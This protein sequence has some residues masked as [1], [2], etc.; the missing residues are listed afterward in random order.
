MPNLHDLK[1]NLYLEEHVDLILKLMPQLQF[2]NGL[3]VER[4]E[5]E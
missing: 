5:Q 2:L 3:P 1:L 4:E